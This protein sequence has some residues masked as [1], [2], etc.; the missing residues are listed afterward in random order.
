MHSRARDTS[1]L[2]SPPGNALEHAAVRTEGFN[3]D[4]SSRYMCRSSVLLHAVHLLRRL[5]P[6]PFKLIGNQAVLGIRSIK[7][8]LRMSSGILDSFQVAMSPSMQQTPP[9]ADCHQC[10]NGCGL[11]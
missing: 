8:L 4:P 2:Q 1:T 5:V 11:G 9:H 10:A 6:S 7:L 3:C